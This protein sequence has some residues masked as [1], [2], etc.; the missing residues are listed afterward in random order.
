MRSKKIVAMAN[1]CL[2]QNAVL[3]GWE[4]ARGAYPFIKILID[5]G[6][7]I[8]Q[9]ACPETLALGIK[10]DPLE[11]EDYN[12]FN[13]RT[14]CKELCKIPIR[15]IKAFHNAGYEFIG[16]IGIAESP[17]CAISARRGVYMEELFEA[18]KNENLSLKNIEVPIFYEETVEELKIEFENRLISWLK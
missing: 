13:H 3:P 2:N 16:T 1:C 10:R 18:L 11:Y 4:R 7:G 15:T 14:L 12:T 17:N 5:Q 9:L 6:I 8:I